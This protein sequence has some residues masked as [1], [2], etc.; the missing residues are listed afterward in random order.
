MTHPKNGEEK[1]AGLNCRS[2]DSE[3]RAFRV[4]SVMDVYA[5]RRIGS[6]SFVLRV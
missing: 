4:A 3:T 2:S 6:P 1:P 5:Y